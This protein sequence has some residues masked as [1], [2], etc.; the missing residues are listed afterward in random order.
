MS[1]PTT[2]AAPVTMP[3]VVTWSCGIGMRGRST[4]SSTLYFAPKIQPTA[5]AAMV[6]ISPMI[7]TSRP[8]RPPSKRDIR[9]A[10]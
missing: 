9:P 10:T 7:Q 6:T 3:P 5:T 2:T 4:R 1:V 8:C